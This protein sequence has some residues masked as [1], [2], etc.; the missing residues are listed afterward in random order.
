MVLEKCKSFFERGVHVFLNFA[1]ERKS[2]RAAKTSPCATGYVA[3]DMLGDKKTPL[4]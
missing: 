1:D 2:R 4:V 3:V